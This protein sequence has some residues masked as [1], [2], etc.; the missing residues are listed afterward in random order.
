MQLGLIGKTLGHSFSKNYF[1][2][3]FQREQL[4]NHSFEL[5]ELP[6]LEGFRDWFFEK[7][8]DGLS[9]TIP[10]KEEVIPF[11]DELSDDAKKI[12]AVNCIQHKEGKLIGHNTDAFGFKNSIRPFIENKFERALILGTG[13]ASKAIHHVLSEWNIPCW[14]VTRETR[15]ENHLAWNAISSEALVHFKLIINC[16]PLGTYPDVESFPPLP[17]EGITADHFL[18]DLVYNPAKTAFLSKGEAQ[19]A[20]IMNGLPMLHLQAERAWE[21]WNS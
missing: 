15:A 1:E 18:Y 3:K 13:G 11:L 21:I 17:Y 4:T 7:K 19:G 8:L 9:V 10:Y 14:F 5:F 6:H 12:G 20:Q 2:E 16:T